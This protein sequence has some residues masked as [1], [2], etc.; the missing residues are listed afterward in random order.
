MSPTAR[1]L[2]FAGVT[3]IALGLLW[4]LAGRFLPFGRLPGDVVIER[5]HVRIYIPVMT[6][7]L[8]S[9]L[10]TILLALWQWLSR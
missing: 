10:L 5:D 3:L 7:I 8:L 2:I 4:Q 6:S 9:L 1:L